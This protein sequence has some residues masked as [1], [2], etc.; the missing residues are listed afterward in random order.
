M[1]QNATQLAVAL[2]EAGIPCDVTPLS[3]AE[4]AGPQPPGR[5]VVRRAEGAL[6]LDF[7]P[8][9]TAGQRAAGVALAE[10]FDWGPGAEAARREARAVA[11]AI[12]LSDARVPLVR[13]I[14]AVA[15]AVYT[16]LVEVR[17]AVNEHTNNKKPPILQNRTWAEVKAAVRQIV[18]AGGGG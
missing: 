11:D 9:A 14:E 3:D 12:A 6:G 8:E 18:K 2:R 4:V 7:R 1:I 5:E 13:L 17:G 15:Y 16:S 10:G